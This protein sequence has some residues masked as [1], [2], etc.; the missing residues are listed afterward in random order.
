MEKKKCTSGS[1][2]LAV[3]PWNSFLRPD[4]MKEMGWSLNVA[5]KGR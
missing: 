4:R 5:L 2:T 3:C 1:K